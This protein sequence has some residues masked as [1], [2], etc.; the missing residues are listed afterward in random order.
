[1]QVMQLYAV[2]IREIL[3][4]HGSRPRTS[5]PGPLS[6]NGEGERNKLFIYTEEPSVTGRE[7]KFNCIVHGFDPRKI[8]A[9][10]FAEFRQLNG[11]FWI[12]SV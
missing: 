9:F 12:R 3:R 11:F 5:P 8:P 10:L 7:M 6:I 4:I 2:L 1:M